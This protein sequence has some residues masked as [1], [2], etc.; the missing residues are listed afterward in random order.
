LKHL[1]WDKPAE[2]DNSAISV[3]EGQQKLDAASEKLASVL[4]KKMPSDVLTRVKEIQWHLR[5]GDLSYRFYAHMSKVLIFDRSGQTEKAIA[6]FEK[7]K[8]IADELKKNEFSELGVRGTTNWFEK[9]QLKKL[10]KL[11]VNKFSGDRDKAE[12][13]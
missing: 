2:G 3:V 4:V 1:Q 11:Y 13:N 9:T 8:K 5:Y 12:T 7:A 6:E 10:F